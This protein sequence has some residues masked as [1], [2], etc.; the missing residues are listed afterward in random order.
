MFRHAA[1]SRRNA[2]ERAGAR[3]APRSS[4]V[5]GCRVTSA[6]WLSFAA[7]AL[8]FLAGPGGDAGAEEA[9][10]PAISNLGEADTT[11]AAKL[12][13]EG[14][15]D[16]AVPLYE[17]AI[18]ARVRAFG[19]PSP[20]V[21]AAL[22]GLASVHV[23]RGDF[24]AAEPLYARALAML[25]LSPRLVAERASVLSNLA[26]LRFQL[27]DYDGAER[28][29]REA[30]ALREASLGPDHPDVAISLSG[31]GRLHVFR[32]DHARAEPLLLRM[33][34]IYERTPGKDGADLAIGLSALGAF[35][36]RRGDRERAEPLL[37]RARMIREKAL[38]GDHPAVAMVL[39]NLGTMYLHAGD[40]ARAEP[41]LERVRAIREKSLGKD[42][43]ELATTLNNLAELHLLRGDPTGA[44]PLYERALAI[45]ERALGDEHPEV[46][47]SLD[48]LAS[49]RLSMGDVDA[50]VSLHE[51]A[52]HVVEHVLGLGLS[53]GSEAQKL[54]FDASY[55]EHVDRAISAHAWSAPNDARAR[56]LALTTVLRHKGLVLD[57]MA[58][59][60]AALRRHLT[61]DDRALL[62][63]LASVE[64]KLSARIHRG[65]GRLPPD[66]HRRLVDALEAE[67]QTLEA[68]LGARS[69]RFREERRTVTV[70][71]VQAALPEGAA[72]V[73]IARYR[74]FD[75]GARTERARFA[76]PARYAAYVLRRTGEPAFADL[77]PAAAIDEAAATFRAALGGAGLGPDPKPAARAAYARIVAPLA[78]L[79]GDARR[80]FLSPDADLALVPF[81]AMMD[82]E[83][84]YLLERYSVVYLT[85]GRDLLRGKDRA[86][87][88]E[89]P[90]VLAA[91]AYGVPSSS[92][93]PADGKRGRR[94]RD[95]QDHL[96]VAPLP[97]TLKEA[98]AIA[99]RLPGAR[100]LV[101]AAATEGAVKA[102]RGPE[103]LHLAT[104]GFFF[105]HG[106]GTESPLVRSGL[107]LAGANTLNGGGDDDG[108]LTALEASE[109][110]LSGTRLVVL[111]ACSTALGKATSGEGVYGLRRA[112]SIAGAETI[113]M[114][115][116]DADDEATRALMTRYY[117]ELRR[118]A[119]R[120]EAMRR[121]QLA[122]LALPETAHPNLWA[123]FIVSGSDEPMDARSVDPPR[124]APSA[125][126]CACRATGEL[127][128]GLWP[129]VAAAIAAVAAACARR[130]SP[131]T[132][133]LVERRLVEEQR[134]AR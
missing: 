127:E 29:E 106:Q 81:A 97:E 19:D 132:S 114:S 91:P 86:P 125:R 72:L 102:A 55:D 35:Y 120:G 95:L 76:A 14:R 27:G 46:A 16:D 79:V 107:L 74:P 98:S 122:L 41:I 93:P 94:A 99:T 78:A 20:E 68:E 105:E 96:P 65:P 53:T 63:R 103:V 33:L 134:G 109:L 90:L 59:G 119:G 56:R 38:G 88:R 6:R 62:E 115:L 3:L 1:G 129:A 100:V 73:E 111:S 30:L 112:L 83:G 71:A 12:E 67:R 113:A 37:D 85:S 44:R 118:G 87:A 15:Y 117:D 75:P 9:P 36:A 13:H 52:G 82:A 8:L 66:E 101:G 60:L 11:K 116:W 131:P 128:L 43:P 28:Y 48:R 50:A 123:S 124:A 32:G 47:K 10:P 69:A 25:E 70:D 2:P 108:I 64:S 26:D 126:G 5:K 58:N 89:G 121:A 24:T 31:L 104:H 17:R 34:A 42:H 57:A 49:L 7:G 133:S 61:A 4:R 22:D 110:D 39:H 84:R 54:A 21:A 92:P 77:G 18:A 80:I 51:R 45:R 130:R 40:L 23:A